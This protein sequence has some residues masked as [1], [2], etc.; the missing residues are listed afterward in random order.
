M[1]I[2]KHVQGIGS[3]RRHLAEHCRRDIIQSCV[4]VIA[5]KGFWLCDALLLAHARSSRDARIIMKSLCE[6]IKVQM[7]R[8]CFDII[9]R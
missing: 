3:V 7:A 9:R 1:L 4:E 5:R 6:S 2:G 8:S